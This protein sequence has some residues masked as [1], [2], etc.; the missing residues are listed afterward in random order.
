MNVM[1]DET[2]EQR[3]GQREESIGSFRRRLLNSH[4]IV[5]CGNLAGYLFIK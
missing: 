1:L 4:S 3:I 5:M 2:D